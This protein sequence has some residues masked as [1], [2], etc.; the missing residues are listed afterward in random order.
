MVQQCLGLCASGNISFSSHLFFSVCTYTSPSQFF[1]L[2]VITQSY[3]MNQYPNSRAQLPAGDGRLQYL[4]VIHPSSPV[5]THPSRPQPW[6]AWN[7]AMPAVCTP[8]T[9]EE[10]ELAPA[11]GKGKQMAPDPADAAIAPL[12]Q[13]Q[14]HQQNMQ[15]MVSTL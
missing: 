2:S 3:S 8:I 11:Q 4:P 12:S 7:G 13:P 15:V 14:K 6:P 10:V 1:K 5:Y 9:T